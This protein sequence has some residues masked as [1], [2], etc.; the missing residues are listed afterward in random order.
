MRDFKITRKEGEWY[1]IAITLGL[2]TI[3]SDEIL[4][5]RKN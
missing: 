2:K 1:N 4:M 5:K 3:G